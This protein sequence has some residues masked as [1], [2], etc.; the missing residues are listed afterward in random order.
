MHSLDAIYIPLM[1]GRLGRE[2]FINVQYEKCRNED[3]HN[4]AQYEAKIALDLNSMFPVRLSESN[5]RR[6]E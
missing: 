3:K 5:H 4:S 6:V 2:L 1:Y